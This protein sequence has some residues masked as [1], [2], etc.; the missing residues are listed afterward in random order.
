[1]SL[2]S[3]AWSSGPG[4]TEV[5]RELADDWREKSEVEVGREYGGEGAEL[6]DVGVEVGG[7]RVRAMGQ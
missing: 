3:L 4:R 5:G 2:S 1:M 7:E 6:G